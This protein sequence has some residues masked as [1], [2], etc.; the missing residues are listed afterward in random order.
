MVIRNDRDL[1]CGYELLMLYG[2]MDRPKTAEAEERFLNHV[3]ELK[4][5]IR[6]FTHR[7]ADESRIVHDDG[8]DGYVVLLPL[9]EFLETM[10]DAKEYFE[11]REV[12]TCRPSMYDCTGQAFTSWY[13]IFQRHGRFWAYHSVCFDV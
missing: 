11:E 7:P 10:E 5:Q 3:C 8:F 4:R 1:R 13:K 9:P 2:E 6:E 12:L